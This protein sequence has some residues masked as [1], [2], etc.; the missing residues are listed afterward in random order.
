MSNVKTRLERL[1]A[2]YGRTDA[3]A[4]LV[5]YDEAACVRRWSGRAEWLTLPQALPYLNDPTVKVY[6]AGGDSDFD[7]EAI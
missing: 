5:L 2:V 7:P 1:E 6:A 4:Y 3:V